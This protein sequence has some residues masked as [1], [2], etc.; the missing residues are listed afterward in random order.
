MIE[1][2]D[3]GITELVRSVIPPVADPELKRDLWPR[4]IQRID[5]RGMRV[6][7]FDWALAALVAALFVC[8]P[9]VIPGLFYHL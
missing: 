2:N 3:E 1:R 4:M 8:F 9:Q 5:Q 7:W 6:T